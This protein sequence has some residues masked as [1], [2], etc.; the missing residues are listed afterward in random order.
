MVLSTDSRPVPHAA[1]APNVAHEHFDAASANA[2]ARSSSGQHQSDARLTGEYEAAA[3]SDAANAAADTAAA[4]AAT[5]AANA[6][7]E[8]CEAVVPPP[9]ATAA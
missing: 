3:A 2:P 1:R 4:V 9:L 8:K 5:T 7:I 6:A